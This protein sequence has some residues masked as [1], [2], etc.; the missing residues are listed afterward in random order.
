MSSHVRFT[1]L[2]FLLPTG[3]PA[4]A[5]EPAEARTLS[6]LRRDL[7]SGATT[8]AALLQAFTERIAAI[9]KEGPQLR[10]GLSSP[11]RAMGE[12][13]GLPLGLSFIGAPWS[14]DQL[15]AAGFAFEQRAQARF[16]PKFIPSLEAQEQAFEPASR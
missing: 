9:D 1:L 3:Q 7:D 11:D 12:L 10:R 15:L 6:E 13:Q 5:A 14:E 16:A 2:L 8:S 4:S